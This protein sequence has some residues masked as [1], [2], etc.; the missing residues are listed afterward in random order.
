MSSSCSRTA[1]SRALN[2]GSRSTNH[3]PSAARCCTPR[4]SDHTVPR[5]RPFHWRA[6]LLDSSV[7]AGAY[8]PCS[9]QDVGSPVDRFPLARAI[10]AFA[11]AKN[12]SL[13]TLFWFWGG[14]G[15]VIVWFWRGGERVP[16][17]LCPLL[18]DCIGLVGNGKALWWAVCHVDSSLRLGM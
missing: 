13:R 16:R 10:A 11:A 8:P 2:A 5:C 18:R 3:R 1:G 17:S 15:P 9:S 14:R 12:I 7:P 4:P 6:L